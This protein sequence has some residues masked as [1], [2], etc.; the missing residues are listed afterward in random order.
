MLRLLRAGMGQNRR[1]AAS[2]WK[3]YPET[4]RAISGLGV[5]GTVALSFYSRVARPLTRYP[6]YQT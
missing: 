2:R 5:G 1:L 4:C 6:S 3:K